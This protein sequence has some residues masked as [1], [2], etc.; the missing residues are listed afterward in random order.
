M[1]PLSVELVVE[2]TTPAAHALGMFDRPEAPPTL[3]ASGVPASGT[4][5]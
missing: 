1:L 5:A 2:A 4:L 3:G